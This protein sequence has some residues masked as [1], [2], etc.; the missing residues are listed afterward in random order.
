MSGCLLCFFPVAAT[1]FCGFCAAEVAAC[2]FQ[3]ILLVVVVRSLAIC[4]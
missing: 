1:E 2:F 4:F 3:A